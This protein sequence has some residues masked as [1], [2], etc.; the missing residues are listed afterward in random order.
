MTSTITSPPSDRFPGKFREHLSVS[1]PPLDFSI[2]T[3]RFSP[4]SPENPRHTQVS[5]DPSSSSHSTNMGRRD[6][7]IE[8]QKTMTS[9]ASSSLTLRD[10]CTQFFNIRTR[11]NRDSE[12][13]PIQPAYLPPWQPLHVEKRR[14]AVMI[15]RAISRAPNPLVAIDS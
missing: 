4:E 1:I 9:P 6:R 11:S 13:V 14:L 12:M 3:S 7:D 10:R 15:A 2:D 8:A 5:W